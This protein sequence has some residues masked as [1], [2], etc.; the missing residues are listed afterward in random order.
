[1]PGVLSC[2]LPCP[3]ILPTPGA[4]LKP[5]LLP[6]LQ[7]QDMTCVPNSFWG[8][9]SD[10]CLLPIICTLSMVVHREVLGQP[11]SATADYVTFAFFGSSSDQ[12]GKSVVLAGTRTEEV[13]YSGDSEPLRIAY[14]GSCCDPSVFTCSLSELV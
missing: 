14:I 11:Y 5:C 13:T 7:V 6:P 8:L 12:S 10:I 3:T 9:S 1:M 4:E 2:Q